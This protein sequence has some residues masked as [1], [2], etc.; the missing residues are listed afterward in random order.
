MK[1][2]LT[3]ICKE[4]ILG[5]YI[6]SG[7]SEI[8]DSLAN[9]LSSHY[10][11]SLLTI[12]QSGS[13]ARNVSIVRKLNAD[14]SHFKFSNVHY[15]LINEQNWFNT[16]VNLLNE[17]QPNI[18]HNFAEPNLIEN[19]NFIP[20]NMIFS[21][22]DVANIVNNEAILSKYN[23]ITT[24]SNAYC[25]NLLR[26]RSSTASFLINQ[27][28][29]GM[30]TALLT[31]IFTPKKGFLIPSPYNADNLKGKALCKAKLL[32]TYGIK[33]NPCIY[34]SGG[35]IQERNLDEI[36]K[37]IPTIQENNGVLILAAKSD[38]FYDKILKQ[39]KS[40]DGII[41]FDQ[42]PSPIQLPTLISGADFF[43][44]PDST[45]MGTLMPL[46]ASNYGTIPILSLNNG[47][48]IDN[49]SEEN[50]IIVENSLIDTI[51]TT[52]NLYNHN[53]LL[54]EKRIACMNM[55]SSWDDIKQDYIALY[56]G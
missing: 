7:L 19:L 48:I 23:H 12:N 44:Q 26:Q 8:P 18:I 10:E 34:F 20:E 56:E 13:L 4:S 5:G 50:A 46:I 22:D 39:Y 45:K 38:V 53:E 29:R 47:T 41:Y 43:I 11:I 15:Y 55:V 42:Y 54:L 16:C 9:S 37:A 49:F 25:T 2:K 30:N 40:S 31:Q 1:K 3:I 36:I 35:I 33:G 51:K 17:I 32:K 28:C 27:N 24:T 52:T 21:F 6:N 14:I